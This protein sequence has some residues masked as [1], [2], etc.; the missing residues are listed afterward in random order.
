MFKDMGG[1]GLEEKAEWVKCL[2]HKH[3][4]PSSDPQ[5]THAKLDLATFTCN[6]KTRRQRQEDSRA[7]M[8]ASRPNS[9]KLQD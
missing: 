1:L 3:E 8:A 7:S 2:L 9:G 5:H 6:H 4:N